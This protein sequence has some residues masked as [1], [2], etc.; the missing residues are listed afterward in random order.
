DGLAWLAL[1]WWPTGCCGVFPADSF[2][3]FG[4]IAVGKTA[5]P[6]GRGAVAVPPV[7]GA[8][9]G[10][11]ALAPAPHSALRKS[12]QF[13]PPSV[14]AALAAWYL[15]LHSFMVSARTGCAE[16]TSSVPA[17]AIKPAQVAIRGIVM[18]AS[19]NISLKSYFRRISIACASLLP[20]DERAKG[21]KPVFVLGRSGTD[22]PQ[23]ELPKRRPR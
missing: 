18:E 2:E 20:R 7:A 10:A 5:F 19:L 8:A 3:Y 14:P 1:C 12:R 4:E 23:I 15:V 11:A 13:W 6:A 16:L 17:S 9:A 22:R 21:S